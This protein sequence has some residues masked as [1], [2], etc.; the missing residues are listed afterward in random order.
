MRSLPLTLRRKNWK[1]RYGRQKSISYE[2][3]Q[4]AIA[5]VDSMKKEYT[6][7]EAEITALQ[8]KLTELSKA[9]ESVKKEILVL[10]GQL[11]GME[12]LDLKELEGCRDRRMEERKSLLWEQKKYNASLSANRAIRKNIEDSYADYHTLEQKYRWI[13][14]LSNTVNGHDIR[15]RTRSCWKRISR[16]PILSGSSGGR[17]CAS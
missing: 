8:E 5:A 12:K 4:A 10:T 17:T 16:P 9:A 1:S 3:K 11:K 15:E 6:E 7:K 2:N 14:S 13:S